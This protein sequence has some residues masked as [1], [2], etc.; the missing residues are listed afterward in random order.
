MGVQWGEGPRGQSRRFR[1][2]IPHHLHG[3][4]EMNTGEVT[5]SQAG[6]PVEAWGDRVRC[7]GGI[8]QNVENSS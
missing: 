1:D 4:V 5:R 2:K 6:D 7:K 8:P 3:F